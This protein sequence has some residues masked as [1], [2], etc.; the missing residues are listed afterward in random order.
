LSGPI[1]PDT[2]TFPIMQKCV[3]PY[4][5]INAEIINAMKIIIDQHRYIVEPSGA[6]SITDLHLYSEELRNRKIV[7]TV[8]GRIFLGVDLQT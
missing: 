5:V 7:V 2:I 6:A 1:D 3:E 4:F 8:T